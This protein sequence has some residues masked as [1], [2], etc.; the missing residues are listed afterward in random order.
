[1]D[2]KGKAQVKDIS[3]KIKQGIRDIKRSKRHEKIQKVLEEFKGIRSIASI[4]DQTRK[5]SSR[6]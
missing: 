1:M 3:K 2:R 4:Q 5:F 6:I